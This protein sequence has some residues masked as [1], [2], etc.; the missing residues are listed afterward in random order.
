MLILAIDSAGNGCS[1]AV[2]Q[3]GRVLAHK[4]E[5]ME[6]GQDSRLMPLIQETMKDARIS[7]AQLD[8]IAVTR[9][10]GSFTGLRIGLAAARGIGLA[11]GKPV[12][13]IDRFSICREKIKTTGKNLFIAINA[14]RPELFCKFYPASGTDDAPTMMTMEEISAFL[15]ATPNTIGTG[16]ASLSAFANY[17]ATEESDTATLA[18]LASVADKSSPETLPRP[19][20]IRAPDVTVKKVTPQLRA[21]TPNDAALLAQLHGESFSE[22]KWDVPQIQGSL[23]L[24]TTSG[25]IASVEG[26]DVGFILTQHLSDEA[27]ILT[28]CVRPAYQHRGIGAALLNRQIDL[29]NKAGSLALL[30]EVA[31]DNTSA[32]KLYE[33]AG[34]TVIG[35]R[36]AYYTRGA[37]KVDAIMYRLALTPAS[38]P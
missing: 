23:A 22:G 20:Y 32:C 8:R 10:P 11:A 36:P 9:G 26:D 13:G 33:K 38:A 37:R 5:P 21:A 31:A 6:R 12:V 24:S 1:A 15:A 34:F 28:F 35:K 2:W 19:L 4:T 17:Q 29:V 7:Y 27:E 18:A 16:D 25:I 3:D 30:L 14:K